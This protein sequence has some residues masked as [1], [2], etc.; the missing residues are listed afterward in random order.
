MLTPINNWL[1][2]VKVTCVAE[3]AAIDMLPQP[4]AVASVFLLALF[5]G[6]VHVVVIV[7]RHVLL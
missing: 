2:R 3:S 6:T 7:C 4:I 1:G 5:L